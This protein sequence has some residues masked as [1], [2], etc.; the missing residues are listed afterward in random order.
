VASARPIVN[1]PAFLPLPYGLWD[2]ADH[3]AAPAH[4]QAGVTWIDQCPAGDTTYDECV[5]VTG[6]DGG[7]VPAPPAKTDNVLQEFR[8]ATPFTVFAEFD[9][10]PVGLGDEAAINALATEALARVEHSQVEAAFW[11]GVAGG[12]T[13]VFPHLA[14]DTEVVDE[15]G[16]VLQPAAVIAAEGTDAVTLDPAVAF[17]QLEHQL[18]QC[19]G[20][21]GVIHV[22]RFALPT[23]ISFRVVQEVGGILLTTTTGNKV[24]VSGDYPGTR[25]NGSAPA[26]ATSWV[27]ATGPV[28][29]Y[30]SEVRAFRRDESFDRAENTVKMIAERTYVFGFPCCLLAALMDLGVPTV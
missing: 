18:D 6:S 12:Q 20:G 14:A 21:R 9:C 8:G 17:G 24:V 15:H 25:P 30:R 19:Y 4:W 26:T 5:I 28:F 13:V 16:I 1:P 7:A 22:P 23:L 29:G 10:S 11:T 27:Y 3:P 2:T